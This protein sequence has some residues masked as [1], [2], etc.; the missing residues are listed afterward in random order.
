MRF[1]RVRTCAAGGA[2]G[3]GTRDNLFSI[4][5]NRTA[6]LGRPPWVLLALHRH[7]SFLSAGRGARDVDV[8]RGAAHRG[9]GGG[10][11]ARP[12]A[13]E[14][15][16]HVG[17]S[18]TRSSSSRAG[19]AARAGAPGRPSRRGIGAGRHAVRISAGEGFVRPL[20][21]LLSELRRRK[22]EEIHFRGDGRGAP[23]RPGAPRGRYRHPQGAR[24]V[25]C[26]RGEARRR[27]AASLSTPRASTSIS[28]SAA[29][30]SGRP[31]SGATTSSATTRLCAS[32]RRSSGSRRTGRRASRSD[33]TPGLGAGERPYEGGQ[34]LCS[35]WPRRWG[36]GHRGPGAHRRRRGSPL[37]CRCSS[38]SH[39]DLR[40]VPRIR[41][42]VNTL[43]AALR[44]A[45]A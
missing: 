8:D 21:Q 40:R 19:R 32:S 5:A 16:G 29:A 18:P 13:A 38:S 35:S 36:A 1:L 34:G 20:T 24:G 26:A 39:R 17:P 15:R 7:R 4:H 44:R 45:L 43:E 11:R 10:A 3:T 6:G 2:P 9:A 41:L 25:A 31:T 33:P 12:R 42:V 22:H 28:G 37:G 27:A 30:G 14:Q 23:R